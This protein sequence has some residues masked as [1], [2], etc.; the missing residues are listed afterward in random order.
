MLSVVQFQVV[1]QLM[2]N[3]LENK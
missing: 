3:D 2:N 1:E